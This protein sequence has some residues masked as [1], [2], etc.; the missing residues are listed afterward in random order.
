M[1]GTQG[2]YGTPP[3]FDGSASAGGGSGPAGYR[4]GGPGGS[5]GS[6]DDT[7]WAVLAHLS[8]FGL[9]FIGPLVI[10]LVKKDTSPFV[11]LHAAEALNFHITL[12]IAT[13]ISTVLILVLIGI[14]LLI[15][16][17]VFGLVGTV[18]AAVA[19]GQGRTFRYPLTLHLLH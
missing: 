5:Q 10:Y 6:S 4:P 8:F 11:R 2:P 3:P 7:I 16:V 9:P 12:T 17:G 19:A 15:A 1:S 14:F 13:A 18:L